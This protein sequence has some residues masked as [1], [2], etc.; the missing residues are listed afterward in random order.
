MCTSVKYVT[1]ILTGKTVSL[2]TCIN[3]MDLHRINNCESCILE[4]I[5]AKATIS[6]YLE[7]CPDYGPRAWKCKICG[8]I[9]SDNS[10]ARKHVENIHFPGIRT[11]S[12]TEEVE[13]ENLRMESWSTCRK[14]M[15]KDHLPSH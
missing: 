12:L 7:K 8:K 5:D 13:D 6:E 2:C 1:R 4:L 9:N 11:Y 14:M 3:I 15:W 10:S